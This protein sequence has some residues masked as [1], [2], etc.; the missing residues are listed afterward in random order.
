MKRISRMLFLLKNNS[1]IFDCIDKFCV[2]IKSQA[3]R[4]TVI[5]ILRAR[6]PKGF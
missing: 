6:M 5:L 3:P 1:K 4:M 2:L